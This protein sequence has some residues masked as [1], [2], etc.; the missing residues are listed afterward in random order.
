MKSGA[1]HICRTLVVETRYKVL[2]F[3]SF[4]LGQ[5]CWTSMAGRYGG[6]VWVHLIFV[7]TRYI[8]SQ[9]GLGV[10]PSRGA[11]AVL[12][13][14]QVE[15]VASTDEPEGRLYIGVRCRGIA[16]HAYLRCTRK[17]GASKRK[18]CRTLVVETRNK[19][20]HLQI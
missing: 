16:M 12:G 6:Q 2:H 8:V 17:Y 3:S 11:T 10:S 9:C 18:F 13:S 1:S 5:V 4:L 20:L 15:Q 14:P 7:E 19:V